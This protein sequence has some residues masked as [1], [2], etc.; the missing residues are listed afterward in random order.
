[1]YDLNNSQICK[2]KIETKNTEERKKNP[3]QNQKTRIPVNREKATAKASR[4]S[5]NLA[6]NQI[7]T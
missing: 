7:K 4:N 1:M 5:L 6:K 2:S 3:A